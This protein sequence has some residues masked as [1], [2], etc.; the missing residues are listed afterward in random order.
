M[1]K[2]RNGGRDFQQLESDVIFFFLFFLCGT[3]TV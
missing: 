2:G 3:L 1:S